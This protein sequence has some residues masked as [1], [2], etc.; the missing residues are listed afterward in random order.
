M[1]AALAATDALVDLRIS[2]LSNGSSTSKPKFIEKTHEKKPKDA[3]EKRI[4]DA[5][6]GKA[7]V[8]DSHQRRNQ[9]N[10]HPGY[11]I[12]NGSHLV[13]N[14][15]NKGRI[16]V[17]IT[18][19]ACDDDFDSEATHQVAPLQ[20]LGAVQAEKAKEHPKLLFMRMGVNGYQLSIM[21]DTSTTHHFVAEKIVPTLGLSVAKHPSHIKVVNSQAQVMRGMAFDVQV[22]IDEWDG[23]MN[24]MMVLLDDYNLILGNDFFIAAKVAIL[25]HLFGLMIH[26]EKKLYFVTGCRMPSDAGVREPKV[27]MV[28]TM[29]LVRRWKRGQM[30]YLAALI[31]VGSDETAEVPKEVVVI[32]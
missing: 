30:T 21:V 11:F 23:R 27:E 5:D 28:S 15:P 10:P 24:L 16:S 18:K 29:Q 14:Y 9:A 25:P 26:D 6:K 3:G 12:C 22:T 32:L 4:K 31:D 20:L 8:E 7:K 19:K 2:K 17:I 13:R 1:P